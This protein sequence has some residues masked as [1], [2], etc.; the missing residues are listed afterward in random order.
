MS[1]LLSV[2]FTGM[3]FLHDTRKLLLVVVLPDCFVE[4]LTGIA[5]KSAKLVVQLAQANPL[6]FKE[7]QK[8]GTRIPSVFQE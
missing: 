8:V 6:H 1:A 5:P 4:N 2:V 3:V 7:R